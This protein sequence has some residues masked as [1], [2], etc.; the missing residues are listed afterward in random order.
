MHEPKGYNTKK[1]GIM[2]DELHSRSP[3]STKLA[4][5]SPKEAGNGSD[6]QHHEEQPLAPTGDRVS[7]SRKR[8]H[9]SVERLPSPHLHTI[10]RLSELL[11]T[12]IDEQFLEIIRQ[13]QAGWTTTN[14]R[15]NTV[16]KRQLEMAQWGAYKDDHNVLTF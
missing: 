7:K 14:G 6:R 11:P 9:F 15:G 10:S 13:L 5:P 12:C 1:K 16:T 2:H 4:T 3:P 8:P